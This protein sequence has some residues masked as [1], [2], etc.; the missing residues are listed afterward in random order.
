[1]TIRLSILLFLSALTVKP[2]EWFVDVDND[3]GTENG[4]SWATAWGKPSDVNWAGIAPGDTI[5]YSDGVY[6]TAFAATASGTAASP[7]TIKLSQEPGH[8][9]LAWFKAGFLNFNGGGQSNIVFNGALSDSFTAPTNAFGVTNL[10]TGECITNNVGAWATNAISG[11]YST[12]PLN[13]IVIRWTAQLYMTNHPSGY[14]ESHG[15]NFQIGSG[16]EQERNILEFNYVDLTGGDGVQWTGGSEA[17]GRHKKIIRYNWFRNIGDDVVQGDQGVTVEGN[18]IEPGVQLSGHA[19][20]AQTVG[21]HITIARNIFL[22]GGLNSFLRLQIGYKSDS[23]KEYFNDIRVF[24]NLFVFET[25]PTLASPANPIEI[26][27]QNPQNAGT[28]YILDGFVF[29][30]NTLWGYTNDSSTVVSLNMSFGASGGRTTNLFVTNSIVANNLVVNSAKGIAFGWVSDL[31]VPP[32]GEHHSTADLI[33]D[34]NTVAATNNSDNQRR[35]SYRGTAHTDAVAFTAA[36]GWKNNTTNLPVFVNAAGYNFELAS[37]DTAALNTGTNLNSWGLTND[38]LGRNRGTTWSRGA[39]ESDA[40]LLV[41]LTFEDNFTLAR[42]ITDQSGNGNHAHQ[43]GYVGSAAGS[44]FPNRVS[45][46]TT[47]GTNTSTYA[48]D[49]DWH[50]DGHGIYGRSGDYGAITNITQLTNLT[51][52]TIMVR[53]RYNSAYGGDYTEDAN[54]ELLSAGSAVNTRLGSWDFGRWNQQIHL[55]QTRFIITT[56]SNQSTPQSGSESDRFFGKAG[57]LVARFDDG[58]AP[59]NDGNSTNWTHY[60]IT[61]NA[62]TL[63]LY[64]NGSPIGTNDVSGSTTTLN[65]G[66]GWIC[67][68]CNT[69]VGTN[70]YLDDGESPALPNNGFMNGQMDDVMIYNRALSA[71][72][73]ASASGYTVSGGSEGGSGGEDPINNTPRLSPKFKN[74]KAFRP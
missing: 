72:E 40:G 74:F 26:V 39:F 73:V 45:A 30:G 60:A 69:H 32:Y 43:F 59:I 1:M 6:T 37:T 33:L 11:F 23:P 68:G 29:A 70:P 38:I 12:G 61:W 10:V 64:Q 17:T 62:G 63:T 36:E 55:N 14:G 47:P 9:G 71:A 57:R 21:P 2:A 25:H 48:G 56:N 28:N 44:N 46:S 7:I 16:G 42:L 65:V 52:A 34:W 19:D 31:S 51:T 27:M 50:A 22:Q 20:N 3:G 13:G 24:D 4:T 18:F 67:V 8:S 35:I 49:F 15:F 41:H 58:W 5:Y 66:A 53:A 54:A